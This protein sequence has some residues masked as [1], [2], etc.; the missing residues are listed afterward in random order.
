LVQAETCLLL[1]QHQ[2]ELNPVRSE[3]VAYPTQ[4]R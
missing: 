2:V 4:D 1:F 3:M